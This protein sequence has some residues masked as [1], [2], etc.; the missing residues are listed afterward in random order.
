MSSLSAGTRITKGNFA[1]MVSSL[2]LA[3][4]PCSQGGIERYSGS[5]FLGGHEKAVS[6]GIEKKNKGSNGTQN[7]KESN[8]SRRSRE[9]S[10]DLLHDTTY[11]DH[12]IALSA[13]AGS[14][15]PVKFEVVSGP[16]E[17]EGQSSL[18][19]TGLGPVTIRAKE[20]DRLG[21]RVAAPVER[22]FEV[23]PAAFGA[24]SLLVSGKARLVDNSTIYNRNRYNGFELAGR[25][26][27]IRSSPG[28]ITRIS[29]LDMDGDL[30]FA[31]LGSA[32]PTTEMII[33]LDPLIGISEPSPYDQPNTRYARGHASIEI[34]NPGFL[35]F[36]SVLSV[37]ND[38]DR[39]DVSLIDR[40]SFSGR[41]N[42]WADIRLISIKD[43]S[44]K[45][46][47]IN[48]ANV[49][50][51]GK[52]GSIGIDAPEV[53][54]GLFAFVGE[55]VPRRRALP[56]IR[57]SPE[58][59]IRFLLITGAGFKKVRSERKI[60]TN[61]IVFPFPIAADSGQLSIKASKRRPDIGS[62]RLTVVRDTFAAS[63]DDYFQTPGQ[64]VIVIEPK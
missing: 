39:V 10:F 38:P 12:G 4:S 34:R 48:A 36:L 9:I 14:G 49:I 37:G 45:I 7:S 57:I 47:G 61:G 33:S 6:E 56:V 54:V 13:S 29:F 63:P 8:Q 17:L 31:E 22:R 5:K 62:G 55:M 32:T 21:C 59:T 44:T 35:T 26:A 3:A 58:S 2:C 23:L 11:G 52:E 42:G 20:K 64:K 30:V 19:L 43:G 16:A 41:A 27:T 60:D 50:F 51:S 40:K 18:I 15:R 28:E 25:A 46:G 53:S 24:E 1:L